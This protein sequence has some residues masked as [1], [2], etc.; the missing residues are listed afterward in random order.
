[1]AS[2]VSGVCALAGSAAAPTAMSLATA[3]NGPPEMVTPVVRAS[4]TKQGY[5]IIGT[6]SGVKLC[7]WTKVRVLWSALWEESKD[8]KLK[9]VVK[10]T[11]LTQLDQVGLLYTNCRRA[12]YDRGRLGRR[13]CRLRA[14]VEWV[15]C[16]CGS[17]PCCVLISIPV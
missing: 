8:S 4:L 6:H 10:G 1:M 9:C 17:T 13:L 12:V 2:V 15:G 11:Q 16:C 7:R 14:A 3:G 5:K